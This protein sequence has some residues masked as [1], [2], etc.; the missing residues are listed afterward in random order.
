MPRTRPVRF[1]PLKILAAADMG[2]SSLAAL[3]LAGRLAR[4]FHSRVTV[5]HAQHFEAPA[6]FTEEQSRTLRREWRTARDRARAELARDAAAALGLEPRALVVEKPA[7]EAALEAARE[8]DADL[9]VV[10]THGRRGAARLWMGSVAEEIL[11]RAERPTLAVGARAADE[12][13]R[14]VLCPVGEGPVG[15][16]ALDYAAA[17]AAALDAK[18]FLLNAA[19]RKPALEDCP[20][21]RGGGPVGC[22][23]VELT[24]A[25]DPAEAVLRAARD[26]SADLVVMGSRRERSAL[27]SLFSSTTQRV[28]RRLEAPLLVVP[29][30]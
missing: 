21:K 11:L 19:D 17:L 13:V 27:G 12:P 10:G 22:E 16:T 20:W 2:P 23:T 4:H 1:P 5:L 25:G 18:L 29:R 14:R 28:M 24:A 30:T 3:R 7:V 8:E 9:V 15:R 26:K 6:Y